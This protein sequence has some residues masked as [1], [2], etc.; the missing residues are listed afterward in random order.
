[1]QCIVCISYLGKLDI[2]GSTPAGY[3]LSF[4]KNA[5]EN[6]DYVLLF[7]SCLSPITTGWHNLLQS[8]HPKKRNHNSKE[9]GKGP[10]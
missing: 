10:Y 2:Y 7:S 4:N 3:L 1:M 8:M 5:S 9:A 6:A